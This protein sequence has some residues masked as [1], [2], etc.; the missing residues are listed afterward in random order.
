MRNN[1][2][3]W[4]ARRTLAPS[5]FDKAGF[6]SRLDEICGK[7][8]LR[9]VWGGEEETTEAAIVGSLGQTVETKRVGRYQTRIRG[10]H[11]RVRINRWIL[12]QFY[13]PEQLGV[14]E[15][16]VRTPRGGLYVPPE[17]A[18]MKRSGKWV[19]VDVIADHSKCPEEICASIEYYCF[20]DYR[21]PNNFDL[22]QISKQTREREQA[23]K[24]SVIAAPD[25]FEQELYAN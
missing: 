4:A 2:R 3:S 7:G 14:S 12:E 25:A 13:T 22:E 5:T 23:A 11:G 15:M 20:G 21:E 6:Q 18:E 9:V 19:M 24:P 16:Y 10:T 1:P 8:V 17:L